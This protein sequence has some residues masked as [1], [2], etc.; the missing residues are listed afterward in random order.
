AFLQD[1]GFC[2]LFACHEIPLPK[3]VDAA[4]DGVDWWS[5]KDLLQMERGAFL[6]RVVRGRATLLSMELLPGF[7]ALHWAE[8]GDEDYR[9]EYEDGRLSADARRIAEFLERNGPTPADTMRQLLAG[10][11]PR[12]T[13]S[14]HS[15]LLELQEQFKV[16]TVGL[17]DRSW[18][19]RVIGLFSRW[20]PAATR[21][22]ARQLRPEEAR[23]RI[24]AA[25][26]RTAGVTTERE[27]S[28]TFAWSRAAVASAVAD[29]LR[30]GQ[31]RQATLRGAAAP[32]LH[33]LP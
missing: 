1:V 12:G 30:Q 14:F 31:I 32:V 13:R 24:V 26:V 11:G 33:C 16:V 23:R 4:R 17:E 25:F 2:L 20:L 19:V 8:G 29:L 15:A 5:W 22:Q 21:R 7:L 28:R 6:G 27:I 10:P 3:L 18:G 9:V